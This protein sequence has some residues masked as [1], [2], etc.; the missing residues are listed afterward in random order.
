MNYNYRVIKT[1]NVFRIHEVYYNKKGDIEFWDE[2]P[3]VPLGKDKNLLLEDLSMFIEAVELPTLEADDILN[4][5]KKR[6]L[7]EDSIKSKC[8]NTFC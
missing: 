4:T 2:I 1:D 6:I 3:L 8:Q 7:I 5:I